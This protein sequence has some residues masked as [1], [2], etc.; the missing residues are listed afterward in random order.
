MA[1]RTATAER[2]EMAITCVST[3]GDVSWRANRW[4]SSLK[5]TCVACVH[6]AGSRTS[7]WRLLRVAVKA[8][9][10]YRV[11]SASRVAQRERAEPKTTSVHHEASP[12]HDDVV[13]D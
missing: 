8:S 2:R 9:G 6:R 7:Q 11:W 4:G 12:R 1:W 13:K 3:A 10:S 5:Q